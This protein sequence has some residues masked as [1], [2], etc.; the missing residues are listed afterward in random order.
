MPVFSTDLPP[1]AL[2]AR[3]L[4]RMSDE[5]ALAQT[6]MLGWVGAEPSP[7]IL[8]WIR[9]RN[10]GGVKI[11]GWNTG[12]T[13]KLAE[14][15]GSLQRE[16]LA[17]EFE[18]PLFVATDQEGGWIR[19]VKGATSETPGNMAIG[20][21]GYPRDAYLSGYYIGQE[22]A[23]LGINMNFAPTVDL[24]TNRESVLI[25]PRSFTSDPVQAGLLG[26]AFARG[27]EAAGVMPTAKH[28]PGH[29]DTDLDSHGV[30][31]QI[32]EPFET[33]WDREL[34][35]Y[36]ILARE[37][38]PAVMSGHLA[39]PN[40]PS[41]STPASLSPWC[42]TTILRG[43]IG[44]K[45]LIIT[46]DLMMNGATMSAG[47]LS[48]AAKEALLAGNDI[49][50]LSKTPLLNDPIWTYLLTSMRA[51]PVF[52][53]RV[54]DAAFRVLAAKLE[55]LRRENT[56]PSVPDLRRVDEELPSAA[57]A[58]FFLDL[59][60]RSV[61]VVRGGA[62]GG[63]AQGGGEAGGAAPAA[64]VIPLLPEQAGRVLLAGQYEEFFSAGRAAYPG[65]TAYWYSLARGA[66]DFAW[67][68]RRADTVVFCISDNVGVTLVR[69]LQNMGKRVILFSVLSPVYLDAAP[70]ADGAIAVYSY[71]RESF[72]AGFSVL[73][74]RIPALGRLPFAADAW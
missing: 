68:V 55:W 49:V 27:Q 50:M 31:P 7:L 10:I 59:A 57:G 72:I 17:G 48:R 13:R 74:G 25:G 36:R 11:F 56:A 28:F 4:E 51:E 42:L 44:V 70:W 6:F 69:T 52:R 40:T 14:T 37:G 66:D 21:S 58:A 71:A 9:D 15:V 24:Y 22:L 39:F 34:V 19:H 26:A 64:P 65:A 1:E 45:G 41:A 29:G 47:S 20:A 12:D 18:I 38:I 32:S 53:E 62:G 2:A 63:S 54:R 61:T 73:A 16:A 8:D 60:A 23:L 5:Q 30:L 46:D 67:F 35:P 43:R 33:L 3:I